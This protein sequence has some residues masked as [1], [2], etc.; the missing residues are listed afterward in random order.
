MS[1]VGNLTTHM[2][3]FNRA[4]KALFCLA[5]GFMSLIA[6]VLSGGG[7]YQGYFPEDLPSATE[8]KAMVPVYVLICLIASAV[9]Y[10]CLKNLKKLAFETDDAEAAQNLTAKHGPYPH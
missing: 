10:V 2:E 3:K 1:P 4:L 6:L 5:F 7:I 8:A 9:A